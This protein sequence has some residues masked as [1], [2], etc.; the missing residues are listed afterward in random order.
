MA[1]FPF[2]EIYVDV[3][4]E[5]KSSMSL[6]TIF[7]EKHTFS[8]LDSLLHQNP[9]LATIKVTR[10]MPI[11]INNVDETRHEKWIGMALANQNRCNMCSEK[12]AFAIWW[13]NRKK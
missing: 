10:L 9:D 13:K 6:E 8:R 7:C 3:E 5:T 1:Q 11:K 2:E 12:P 4:S